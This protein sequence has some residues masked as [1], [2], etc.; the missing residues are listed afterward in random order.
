MLVGTQIARLSRTALGRS[1]WVHPV[2]T[3]TLASQPP[4]APPLHLLSITFALLMNLLLLRA[5][6]RRSVTCSQAAFRR[7]YLGKE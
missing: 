2:R 5:S 7:S 3:V 1:S 4:T 6:P